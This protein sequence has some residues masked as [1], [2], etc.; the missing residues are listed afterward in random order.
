MFTGIV[1][2][3][4]LV[5]AVKTNGSNQ[6][7][8]VSSPLGP[9]LKIDQSLAHNGVCLTIERLDGKDHWVTAVSET[10]TKTN[11]GSWKAGDWVNLERSLP[12]N[13]RLDGH[14]VQ[15]HVDGLGIC[16]GRKEKGGSWEFQFSYP[17]NFAPW[18]IEKGSICVDGVSL[19]AFQVSRNSFTVAIIPYTF[20]HTSFNKLKVGAPVNLE[21]DLLGKYVSRYLQ[22]LPH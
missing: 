4:G 21:F 9:E 19:T 16:T 13:G 17:E 12:L 6:T 20:E 11:L 7:F 5:K 18:V 15:G 10:L 2:S 3:T 14:L 8:Q 1:E 22:L